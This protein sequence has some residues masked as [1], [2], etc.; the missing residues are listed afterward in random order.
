G[1]V[2]QHLCDDVFADRG[3]QIPS[4]LRGDRGDQA[5]GRTRIIVAAEHVRG[6]V[7]G[8]DLE[9]E[10]VLG[11]GAAFFS[12]SGPGDDDR[13]DLPLGALVG[14]GAGEGVG[15][16]VVAV[17]LVDVLDLRVCDL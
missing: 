3:Q 8:G 15:L 17:V 13:V 11:I 4:L 6:P 10:G 9:L 7:E 2:G 5:G 1:V 14:A 12:L 16:G